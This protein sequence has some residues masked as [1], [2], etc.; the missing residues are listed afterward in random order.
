MSATAPPPI[1]DRRGRVYTPAIGT[2]LRPWLWI[3]LIGFALLAANGAYLASVTFLGWLR[4][5]VTQ[6]TWFSLLMLIVHLALGVVLV[7]PFVV[8][9]LAH[10]VTSWKRPNRTAV[11]FGLMLLATSIVLLVTG[12]ALWREFIDVRD[13]QVRRVLYWLHVLTPLLAM[14]LYLQHRLA[15]PRVKWEWG[16]VWLVAVTGFI[17]IMAIFHTHDPRSDRRSSDPRYT[18]PSE[19]KL[20]GGKLI[21]EESMLMDE[22]CLKCH[23]D[24]YEGWFHSSHHFSSFNNKAYLFSVR[25]TRQ[26]ALKRDGDMRAARWCAGCHDPVPFFSGAFDDPK[27]DDVNTRSSQAGITCTVCHAITH[28]NSTRGNAD[29]TIEEP[30]HY[31]FAYSENPVPPVA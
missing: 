21:S 31:P 2:G 30:Q 1:R 24:A 25:E 4:G 6:A 23:Q 19:V 18:F 20:A 7:V 10:L 5:D 14:A 8:F 26:V 11:R 3:I 15:G 16:R 9:G 27:Y 28:V 12:F 22:Y 29:Y 17:A 13:P